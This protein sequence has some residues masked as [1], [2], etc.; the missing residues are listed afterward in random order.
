MAADCYDA[1]A[2]KTYCCQCDSASWSVLADCA[3][4][5]H[6]CCDDCATREGKADLVCSR[7]VLKADLPELQP[8]RIQPVGPTLPEFTKEVA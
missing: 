2:R 7:C 6:G 1:W 4:S 8:I 3:A 5:G